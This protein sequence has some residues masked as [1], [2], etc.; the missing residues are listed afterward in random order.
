MAAKLKIVLSGCSKGIGKAIV[1]LAL[2][3]GHKVLGISRSASGIND[4][5][6]TELQADLLNEASFQS[7]EEHI[8]GMGGVD[9]LI[10]NAGYLVNKPFMEVK[11]QDVKD[12]FDVNYYAAFRLSQICIPYLKESASA[13]LINIG[14]VGGVQGSL[15]FAG[16]SA[17]SSSKGAIAILTECLAEEFKDTKIHF[18]CLALGA[19]QTEMLAQAFPGYQAPYN[20][21]QMAAYI[22]SFIKDASPMM[23]GKIISVSASN[24]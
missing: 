15:K 2:K 18:N 6:Y 14:S 22:L 3:E 12:S 24:P 23:N 17:Y 19:V 9:V 20:P 8:K 13:A 21:D 11:Y 10:N 7:I 16:L 5:N 4:A 1:T